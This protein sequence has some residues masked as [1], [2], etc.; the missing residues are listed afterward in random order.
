MTEQNLP[1]KPIAQK[2]KK[3]KKSVGYGV[4]PPYL[5]LK[6]ATDIVRKVYDNAGADL[7]ED[8]LSGIFQN[9]VGSSSFSL[10]LMALKSFG[11][12]EQERRGAPIRLT[13]LACDIAAPSEPS[14]RATAKRDSF[15]K[16]DTYAK[17]HQLWAGKILPS[18]EFFLN[19]LRERCKIPSDLTQRWKDSF[20]ESALEAA[21]LQQRS[22]GK[23]QV[24]SEP[25]IEGADGNEAGSSGEEP[26]SSPTLNNAGAAKPELKPPFTELPPDP[27]AERY[28]IP[29]LGEGRIGAIELPRGWSAADVLKMIRVMQVML[30]PD[31]E[32]K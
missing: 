17:L 6:Q 12:A 19:T 2:P 30:L 4:K 14:I 32:K 1:Q 13:H 16:I 11:L 25:I 26:V 8:S 21:L 5:T 20:I 29:L 7:S 18:G 23:M 22:D 31:E 15:L 3:K 10:K 28:Q 9:S 24:R 27:R